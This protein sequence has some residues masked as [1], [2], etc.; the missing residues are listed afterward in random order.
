MGSDGPLHGPCS[1]NFF[2]RLVYLGAF[3]LNLGRGK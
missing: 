1:N 3:L 2:A